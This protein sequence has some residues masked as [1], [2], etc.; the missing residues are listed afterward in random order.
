MANGAVFARTS[1][2]RLVGISVTDALRQALRT[3]GQFPAPVGT[4]ECRV[5][6]QV[7]PVARTFDPPRVLSTISKGSVL[8][9]DGSWLT[10]DRLSLALG[11]GTYQAEIRGEQYRGF[12][13]TLTWPLPEG[14]SRVA[15]P[16]GTAQLMPGPSY[17]LPDGSTSR[18][19]LGPTLIRGCLFAEDGQPRARIQVEIVGL[20]FVNV[21]EL[22]PL[23]VWPFIIT[24]TSESG[25]WALVLPSRR[26]FDATA[27]QWP[28]N[29][30][31]PLPL[32]STFTIK[33]S[34]PPNAPTNVQMPVE[35]AAENSLRNTALRGRVSGRGGSPL[36]GARIS[37]NLN[38]RRS[39]TR[40]DGTWFLYFDLNQQDASP[41][42]VTATL[43]N[44]NALSASGMGVKQFSTVVVPTFQFP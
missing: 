43:P 16:N 18:F 19:Q 24:E 5:L 38:A 4:I 39:V 2:S 28:L 26:Y 15:T 42:T 23:G 13:F 7:A 29:N 27:E 35:F 10:A 9:L 1:H 25:D 6:A 12:P 44:G 20:A 37:T 40:P 11:S 30:L 32:T 33:V 22:P 17:A 3:D 14:Q 36:A 21:P 8:A 34:D 41:V 31:P